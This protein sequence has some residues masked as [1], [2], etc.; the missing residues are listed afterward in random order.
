LVLLTTIGVGFGYAVRV[1]TAGSRALSEQVRADAVAAAGVRRAIAGLLAEDPKLR[2]RT[3]GHAREMPW[4]DAILRTSVRSE[5][6]KIDLNAAPKELLM[7]L[8]ANLLPDGNA[9]MLADAVMHA[10]KSGEDEEPEAARETQPP[11]ARAA[12]VRGRIDRTARRAEKIQKP[13]STVDALLQV[14][15]FDPADLARLRPYLTVHSGSAKVDV[16]TADLE[17]LAAIPGVSRDAALRFVQDR[18]A[19]NRD[20]E[21]L[22]LSALGAAAEYVEA[23]PEAEV[24]NIRAAAY[25]DGGS[26]ATVEAVVTRDGRAG[27]TVLEW[28]EGAVRPGAWGRFQ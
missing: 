8:F 19:P 16:S 14:P 21:P 22:D 7:G 24:I 11:R 5:S 12:E 3:D 6:A 26:S 25:L 10:R 23:R 1:E 20:S 2:W 13:F 18:Q 17:V 28:S 4:P 15:G 27:V 9:E